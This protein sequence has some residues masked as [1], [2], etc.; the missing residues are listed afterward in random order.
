MIRDAEAGPLLKMISTRVRRIL[1]RF[2][3]IKARPH[4]TA[5]LVN[6]PLP[7]T[8]AE[9]R[10]LAVIDGIAAAGEAEYSVPATDGRMIRLL[11]EAAGARNV[12]EIGTSVGYSGLWL[13]LA[14]EAT[15]GRLTTFEVDPA[16]VQTA[17]RNFEAAG[18]TRLVTLVEGDACQTARGLNDPIDVLFLD[19]EKEDYVRQLELL[20]P[21]VRPGGLILAHN[22]P[23]VPE[24]ARVIYANPNL[25]T[26]LYLDAAGLAITLKKRGAAAP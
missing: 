25:E 4:K 5:A 8:E 3:Y 6:P 1:R 24:Y 13:C 23:L 12:V 10:I 20:L 19:A 11:T 18:V 7:E 22:F 16:K 2:G 26:V 14:L 15:G 9:K 21:L 17:R